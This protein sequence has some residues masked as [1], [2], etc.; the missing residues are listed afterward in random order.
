MAQW[1]Y[2][3]AYVDFRGRVSIE[4]QEILMEKEER[5][6]AFVRTVLDHLGKDGWELAGVH[7]LWPAETSYMIFKRPA[8]GKSDEAAD[9]TTQE[10]GNKPASEGAEGKVA[11]GEPTRDIGI[12]STEM[13]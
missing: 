1:E 12:E 4:G 13:V 2:R 5:R 7:P 10:A 11:S 3:V 8:E 9:G 6:S